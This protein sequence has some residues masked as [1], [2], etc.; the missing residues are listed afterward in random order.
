M[1][2]FMIFGID[3]RQGKTNTMQFYTESSSGFV[4]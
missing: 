4:K 2:I 1:R 3:R